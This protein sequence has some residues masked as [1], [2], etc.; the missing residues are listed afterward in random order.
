MKKVRKAQQKLNLTVVKFYIIAPLFH[1]H[2]RQYSSEYRRCLSAVFGF[3]NLC[4]LLKSMTLISACI[5][6]SD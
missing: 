2:V 6:I 1:L 4:S 3:L 5:R